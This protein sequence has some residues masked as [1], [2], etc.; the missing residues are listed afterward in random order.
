MDARIDNPFSLDELE[1]LLSRHS[2]LGIGSDVFHMSPPELH[3]LYHFLT[4]L[5]L[6]QAL[7]VDES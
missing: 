6:S 1:M 3:G 5:Q 7:D 4:R 2:G